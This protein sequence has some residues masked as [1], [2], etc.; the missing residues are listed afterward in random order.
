MRRGDREMKMGNEGEKYR[1]NEEEGGEAKEWG[2]VEQKRSGKE[3]RE[4]RRTR[5]TEF[6]SPLQ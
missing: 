3:W 5:I 2:M 1:R 4:R 6:S